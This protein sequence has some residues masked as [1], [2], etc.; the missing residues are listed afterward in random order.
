MIVDGFDVSSLLS[1]EGIIGDGCGGGRIF[2]VENESLCVYD[3]T[4][5]MSRI[6]LESVGR[7]V[8]ISKKACIISLYLANEK[9]EFDLST[10]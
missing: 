4:T 1:C 10:L 7:V 9:I 5:K 6:L 3:P 8:E 2:F